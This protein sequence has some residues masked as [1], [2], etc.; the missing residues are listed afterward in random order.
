MVGLVTLACVAI[1]LGGTVGTILLPVVTCFGFWR[2]YEQHK[3]QSPIWTQ[4]R[5]VEASAWGIGG[6]MGLALVVLA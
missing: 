6:L 2:E 3:H 4:H 5:L 1:T